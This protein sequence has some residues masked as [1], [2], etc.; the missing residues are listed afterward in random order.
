[1]CMVISG[2]V[3]LSGVRAAPYLHSHRW[4]LRRCG[5][6]L[7]GRGSRFLGFQQPTHYV[8]VGG[9]HLLPCSGPG[10]HAAGGLDLEV[11]PVQLLLPFPLGVFSKH[12]PFLQGFTHDPP[13]PPLGGSLRLLPSPEL[14]TQCPLLLKTQ[15]KAQLHPN[16]PWESSQGPRG[17]RA[18]TCLHQD[19]PLVYLLCSLGRRG[20]SGPPASRPWEGG[21]LRG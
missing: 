5:V 6:C 2:R 17:T 19:P 18:K 9:G 13:H 20:T 14:D 21:C 8:C 3:L 15:T 10:P 11:Q 12:T 1:M 4:A 7:S 16:T